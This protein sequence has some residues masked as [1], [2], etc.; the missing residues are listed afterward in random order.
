VTTLVEKHFTDRG[1]GLEFE[2]EVEWVR[3]A[4]PAR[5]RRVL[6]VGCGG[7]DLLRAIDAPFMIGLDQVAQGLSRIRAETPR[8]RLVCGDSHSLPVADQS[9]DV[10]LAQHVIEHLED[11]VRA[12][13]EWLRVLRPGGDLLVLTPNGRFPDTSVF[14]DET[15]V[16]LFNAAE[17]TQLL[18]RAGFDIRERRTLGLPWFRNYHNVP[19][20]WRLRRAV[21]TRAPWLS[22][23]A[24]WRWKG[25]TLCCAARRPAI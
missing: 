14:D 13:R 7:V 16:H 20:G 11:P 6:D 15:H 17:L 1:T 10:V 4:L 23:P 18:K 21:T 2:M 9:V 25:Q 5:C 19:G 12:C 8:V 24:M 3:H 22:R